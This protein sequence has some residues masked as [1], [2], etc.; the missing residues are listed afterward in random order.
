MAESTLHTFVS[1]HSS[2]A[3]LGNSLRQRDLLAPIKEQVHIK[4]KTV[5]YTPF[6]KLTDAFL[7][8][9]TGAHRMVEI[10]TVVRAD[11]GLC[12]AFG[13]TACAEQSVVQDTLDA[14]TQQNLTQMH[15]ALDAIFRKH[16]QAF[17]HNYQ[18]D[19]QILDLDLSGRPCG[20]KA[21]FAT[22]GYFSRQPNRRGRQE[23]RVYASRYDETVCVRLFT[24]NTNTSAALLP[25]VAATEQTLKL[26]P[27]QKAR[28][29]LRVDAGGGT[30]EAVNACLQEGYQILCK[31]YSAGRAQRLCQSIAEWYDDPKVLGRQVGLVSVPATEYVRPVVRI[32]VRCPKK[33]GSYSSAVLLT[34]LTTDQ[35]FTLIGHAPA[36]GQDPKAVLLAY[37]HLYDGRGGGIEIGF[38]QDRQGLGRRNKKRAIAQEILLCLEALAH[39][40]LI[41]AKGWLQETV[42]PL[43]Q[44]GLLRL[45]RDAL[46]I[47]GQLHLDG[48]GFLHALVLNQHHPR[49]RQMQEALQ[50]LLA[51]QNAC[52]CLGEI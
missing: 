41:W 8:L 26:T 37:V 17:G 39:N 31:D 47:S 27:E 32:A 4:Q 29:L 25:L 12:Q 21:E 23:G 20:K 6:Q 34:T 10:N 30:L 3:A 2:L 7:L 14:C 28:T 50:R 9:L 19:L 33:D 48:E 49:A 51:Q 42:K 13:R 40:V 52:I 35:L 18:A 5:K 16:S 24:G 15:Q 43:G 45:V 38:K 22:K 11:V 36:G 46:A 1:A 44:L